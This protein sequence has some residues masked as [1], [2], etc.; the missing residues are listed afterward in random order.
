MIR[1][2]GVS[3]SFAGRSGTVEAL[4]QID[5]EVAEGEFV[6]VLGRSGCGKSTLL[7]MIA[8]LLPV[9]AGEITVAGT[10]ITRPRR[11]IAMLFQRPALLPWRSVLDNVLLPVEIFGWRR[12]AH[13]RRAYELL[14]MAGLVGF[15]RRLPHELSG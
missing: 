8:G 4:R 13:R 5:L 11:D 10:P 3:R 9:S 1:L 6:A 7:R 2:T 14:A 12:T 15:E